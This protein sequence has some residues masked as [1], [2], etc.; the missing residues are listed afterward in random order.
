MFND[1]LLKIAST[2]LTKKRFK[3]LALILLDRAAEELVDFTE[4][5]IGEVSFDQ[6]V[7]I[8]RDRLKAVIEEKV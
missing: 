4:D 1:V 6:A 7:I 3:E 2:I 5:D 8:M